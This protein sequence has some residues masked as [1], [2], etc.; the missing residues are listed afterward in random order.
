MRAHEAVRSGGPRIDA[1]VRYKKK[2]PPHCGGVLCSTLSFGIKFVLSSL[3]CSCP[4]CTALAGAHEAGVPRHLFLRQAVPTVNARRRALLGAGALACMGLV[5]CSGAKPEHVS[6][7]TKALPLQKDQKPQPWPY[8]PAGWEV[9]RIA[10]YLITAR[11][12]GTERYR[13]DEFSELSPLDLALA[14]GPAAAPE[15]QAALSISQSN[16]WYYWRAKT[17]PLS[18]SVLNDHMANV[19]MV[20]ANPNVEQ[21]L[22]HLKRGMVVQLQGSL[23]NAR[24]KGSNRWYRSSTSRTDRGGGACEILLVEQ[25]GLASS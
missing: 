17:L 22:N 3:T 14:W 25:V 20:P 5:G 16:R 8:A 1:A 12:I 9:V 24:H 7:T 6:G 11:V 19:H 10:H 15:V 21:L 18:Q 23:I 13:F 2:R 4:S